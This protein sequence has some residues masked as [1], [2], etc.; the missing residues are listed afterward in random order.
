MLQSAEKVS[1][2]RAVRIRQKMNRDNNWPESSLP[3]PKVGGDSIPSHT[4]M[5]QQC[6]HL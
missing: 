3:D 1:P 6:P 5:M 2:D 4:P